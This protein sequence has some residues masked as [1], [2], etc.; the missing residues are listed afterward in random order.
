MFLDHQ[1]LIIRSN[2]IQQ[3]MTSITSKEAESLFRNKI[4]SSLLLR[5]TEPMNLHAAN[6]PYYSQ[7]SPLDSANADSVTFTMRDTTADHEA[8]SNLNPMNETF[9]FAGS[10]ERSRMRIV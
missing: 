10:M 8:D 1:M 5:T 4:V 3:T 6:W 7:C 9:K 2:M